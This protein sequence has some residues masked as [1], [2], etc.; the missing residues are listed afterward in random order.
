MQ[1]VFRY[2]FFLIN[3]LLFV[4]LFAVAGPLAYGKAKTSGNDNQAILVEATAVK[5][6]RFA[7]HI[8]LTGTLRA[9]QGIVVRPEVSGRIVKVYFKSGTVVKA[10]TPLLKLNQDVIL[11][12][13][14][15][16]QAELQLAQQNYVR[17]Q[18]LYK[19][20][21]IARADLDDI[22]AK[23]HAASAKVSEYQAQLDQTLIKASFNGR[24]GLSSVN[25]G[26][27]VNAGQNLVSLEAIDP[28][29]VEFNVPQIY[30]GDLAVGQGVVVTTDTYA[31]QKFLGKIYAIDAQ[32]D[33]SN[34]TVAVRAVIPNTAGKLLPGA[35][36][37]V[38]LDFTSKD[39]VLVIP[40]VAVVY[41]EKQAYVYKV[42]GGKVVKVNVVLGERDR[43]NVTVVSG[44]KE[45]DVV[46]TA[47]QLNIENGS[48]VT[49][50]KIAGKDNNLT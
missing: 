28:V 2:F 14:R 10:G 9:N 34:R 1:V 32:V 35:F 25:L 47:G 5:M 45:Q 29:E 20:H 18:K 24:L 21:T 43:E 49:V 39:A 30:L 27:Y 36:V 46:V 17:M 3:L 23:L 26:D 6:Q 12:E 4:G 50:T 22:T 16:S 41:D 38:N 7:N 11:A 8:T 40:Q 48:R 42:V 31:G 33:L 19:T 15:Q 44:L 37:E 13:L